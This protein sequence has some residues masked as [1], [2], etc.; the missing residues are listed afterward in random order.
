MEYFVK[1]VYK[2]NHSKIYEFKTVIMKEL[3]HSASVEIDYITEG[4]FS[5]TA[6]KY[7][8]NG[9]SLNYYKKDD[10]YI[11][12]VFMK[13]YKPIKSVTNEIIYSLINAVY[14]LH[15]RGIYHGDIKN[16]NIGLDEDNN[17]VIYDWTS[18]F[19]TWNNKTNEIISLCQ[20]SSPEL[21]KRDEHI[22]Y[23]KCDV[24]AVGLLIYSFFVGKFPY[25]TV[26]T[27]DIN[28]ALEQLKTKCDDT[29]FTIARL[30]LTSDPNAR[31][32]IFYLA[33]NFLNK[34][35][36]TYDYMKK[37]DF[38]S[39]LEYSNNLK[40]Y[41]LIKPSDRMVVVEWINSVCELLF[42][43]KNI[44]FASVDMFDLLV[45]E[46][47]RDDYQLLSCVCMFIA[48][49]MFGESFYSTKTFTDLSNDAFTGRTIE[50]LTLNII[51]K[52]KYKLFRPTLYQLSDKIKC[53]SALYNLITKSD[54]LSIPH[55]LKLQNL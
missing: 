26:S 55:S 48:A 14:E 35:G 1:K 38:D 42:L 40:H 19:I 37:L 39:S 17:V 12:R 7:L 5:F 20:T 28:D 54:Q 4:I 22:D 53:K 30:C 9:Y 41:N 29:I 10:K 24:W 47:K 11:F 34:T 32:D 23:F 36:T 3:E 15:L 27:T 8:S 18:S 6:C 2:G 49:G 51:M 52:F 46:Y 33:S 25:D 16:S 21:L 13:K 43:N 31:P 44:F 45:F 50:D